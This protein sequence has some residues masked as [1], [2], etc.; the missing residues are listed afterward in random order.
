MYDLAY[1]EIFENHPDPMWIYD[2]R[3]FR[4]LAV[5]QAAVEHYG[6]SREE[7]LAMTIDDICPQEDVVRLHAAR[8]I[9]GPPVR[10]RGLW[11]HRRWDGTLIDVDITSSTI[12]WE[13]TTAHAVMVRDVTERLRARRSLEESQQALTLAQRVGRMGGWRVDRKSGRYTISDEVYRLYGLERGS[14][15]PSPSTFV[16]R[17]H[18]N[19]LPARCEALTRAIQ[20]GQ[21]YAIDYRIVRPDG[22]VRWLHGRAEAVLDAS[23]EP[24]EMVGV[25]IDITERKEAELAVRQAEARLRLM[26]DQLPAIAWNTDRQL[27]FTSIAGRALKELGTSEERLI[28]LSLR[29]I[30]EGRDGAWAIG[31][32]EAALLGEAASREVTWMTCDSKTFRVHVEPL[33]EKSGKIAGVAGIALDVTEEISAKRSLE[34]WAYHDALTGLPNRVQLQRELEQRLGE[35]QS[36]GGKLAVIFID[37]DA[38]AQIN[39][40]FGHSCGDAI[41]VA[42]A[43]RI[44]SRLDPDDFLCRWGGDEFVV[45][46]R[47]GPGRED[48]GKH[49][50]YLLESLDGGFLVD[51]QRYHVEASAGVGIA[52]D[53]G[54]NQTCLLRA[55]DAAMYRAKQRGRGGHV[56]FDEQLYAALQRRLEVE[57]TLREAL[58]ENELRVVYQPI[59]CAASLRV[60][61]VEVLSRWESSSLG[62]VEPEEFIPIAEETRLIHPIGAW[63]LREACR[64]LAAWLR[65]G[66]GPIRLCAN[67]SAHQLRSKTFFQSVRTILEETGLR[68]HLLELELTE[69]AMLDSDPSTLETLSKLRDLGV[70]LSIDDFGTG[71]SALSCL[72]TMRVDTVKID[73][74]FIKDVPHDRFGEAIARSIVALAHSLDLRVIAEGVETLAQRSLLASIG[75]DELQGFLLA[76]PVSADECAKLLTGAGARQDNG[77]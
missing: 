23:G 12:T 70:C 11:R 54:S 1:R 41:L 3:T 53:H 45:L 27:R 52:P 76:R 63:V 22:A 25:V 77:Q 49:V 21:P 19:D 37:L 35:I 60:V 43:K 61:G 39:N 15:E 13:G 48:A 33:Y 20:E 9:G 57:R 40:V 31:A 73:R 38:F 14:G 7:F 30:L 50:E 69:R 36:T 66:L 47:M 24:V 6:Y 59:W 67:V 18:P 51:D 42:A 29:E 74:L 8:R 5:N 28:G 58:G 46:H 17:T 65:A 72:K 34:H 75:C 55:A 26:Y 64:Q 2:S 10:H 68:P 4:F 62:V 16:E 56:V 71:Y 32:H 44:R